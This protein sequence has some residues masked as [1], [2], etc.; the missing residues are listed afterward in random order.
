ALVSVTNADRVLSPHVPDLRGVD[1]PLPVCTFGRFEETTTDRSEVTA[2][3]IDWVSDGDLVDV[4]KASF[5][6]MAST[7][8]ERRVKCPARRERTVVTDSPVACAVV[9][10]TIGRVVVDVQ[11]RKRREICLRWIAKDRERK[12]MI[13]IQHPIELA[14]VVIG[15]ITPCEFATLSEQS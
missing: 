9:E 14:G 2:D 4:G 6:E 10:N 15:A 5:V 12:L 3:R 1:V 11:K 7:L 8:A 13:W